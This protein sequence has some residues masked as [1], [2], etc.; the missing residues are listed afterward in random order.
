M[1]HTLMINLDEAHAL[2]LE[3]LRQ[4]FQ[5]AAEDTIRFTIRLVHAQI[6]SEEGKASMELKPSS[7]LRRAT[8]PENGLE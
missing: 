1:R 3:E 2:Q 8:Y 7:A 4:Q 5:L 6:E